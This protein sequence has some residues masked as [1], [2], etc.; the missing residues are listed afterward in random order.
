M[1]HGSWDSKKK[2]EF[3]ILSEMAYVM[4]GKAWGGIHSLT[5]SWPYLYGL[6]SGQQATTTQ[7][8]A[9]GISCAVRVS[10]LLIWLDGKLARASLRDWVCYINQAWS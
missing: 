9:E 10:W 3:A 8:W 7:I 2:D 4:R 6:A 5:I 1:S